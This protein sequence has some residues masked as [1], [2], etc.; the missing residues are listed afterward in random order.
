MEWSGVQWRGGVK[1]RGEEG[2]LKTYQVVEELLADDLDHLE[3]L[4]R[5]D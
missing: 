4:E 3:G 5:G 1:R 2:L